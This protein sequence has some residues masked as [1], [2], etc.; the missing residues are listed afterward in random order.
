MQPQMPPAL[1]CSLMSRRDFEKTQM[2]RQHRLLRDGVRADHH[3]VRLSLQPP[4]SPSPPPARAETRGPGGLVLI[5]VDGSQ[6]AWRLNIGQSVVCKRDSHMRGAT[7]YFGHYVSRSG[8]FELTHNTP[9]SFALHVFANKLGNKP[10][11]ARHS[12]L[13]SA[14][15]DLRNADDANLHAGDMIHA[16]GAND[17]AGLRGKP[18]ILFAIQA[19][20]EATLAVSQSGGQSGST[21]DEHIHLS[22]GQHHRE[23][24]P[25]FGALDIMLL[26]ATPEPLARVHVSKG[27][28]YVMRKGSTA[29]EMI[30]ANT[31]FC[32][33]LGDTFRLGGRTYALTPRIDSRIDS[34][35]EGV[36][37]RRPEQPHHK[38]RRDKQSNKRKAHPTTTASPTA[39]FFE[40]AVISSDLVPPKCASC[41]ED[42]GKTELRPHLNE[43][44]DLCFCCRDCYTGDDVSL[45]DGLAKTQLQ[46]ALMRRNTAL[47]SYELLEQAGHVL[48]QKGPPRKKLMAFAASEDLT[49]CRTKADFCQ[50]FEEVIEPKPLVPP[51]D[52][53]LL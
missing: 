50:F 3:G 1:P 18:A 35:E 13:R 48:N 11:V 27:G 46:V 12:H 44:N 22:V 51:A 36:V 33:H 17:K 24:Q 43:I 8:S 34:A 40:S 38:P 37:V 42:F 52:G 47:C 15:E 19:D 31:A 23:N 30:S 32:C 53:F 4:P 26:C 39:L 25:S 20:G 6:P 10:R 21:T 29:E 16:I 28:S 45:L 14:E 7:G 2:R 9:T 49:S 5:R 41:E